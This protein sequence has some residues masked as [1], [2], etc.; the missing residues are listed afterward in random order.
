M[1]NICFNKK[2]SLNCKLIEFENYVLDLMKNYAVSPE[3][4]LTGISF[5]KWWVKYR[6]IKGTSYSLRLTNL[7]NNAEN[8]DKYATG[9]L[10]IH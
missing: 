8:Y 5:M 7:T 2:E 6:K 4:F 9:C 3:I 10:V 1:N